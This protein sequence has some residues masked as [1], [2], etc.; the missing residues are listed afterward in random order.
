MRCERL[1][2]PSSTC[3]PLKFPPTP[4]DLFQNDFWGRCWCNLIVSRA[5]KNAQIHTKRHLGPPQRP[6]GTPRGGPRYPQRSPKVA[7]GIPQTPPGTSQGSHRA[8]PRT[9]RDPPR[10]PQGTPQGPPRI[11]QGMPRNLQGPP[12]DPPGAPGTPL[13][14]PRGPPRGPIHVLT[15]ADQTSQPEHFE[16]SRC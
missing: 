9:P 1:I 11:P 14:L 13:A 16:K 5:A 6:Q 12:E 15:G 10:D 7:P 3:F 4:T 8:P 2:G